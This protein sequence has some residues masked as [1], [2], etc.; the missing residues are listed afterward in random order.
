MAGGY[1][2]AASALILADKKESHLLTFFMVVCPM[3]NDYFF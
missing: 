2:A 3:L 1:V